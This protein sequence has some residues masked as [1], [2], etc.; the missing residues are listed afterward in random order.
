MLLVGFVALLGIG[1][2]TEPA[3]PID[4]VV[5][6]DWEI[7]ERPDDPWV[8]HR[9]ASKRACRSGFLVEDGLLEIETDD[10][11]Y[12][13]ARQP[14]R[15]DIAPGDALD[16]LTWHSALASTTV[17]STAHYVITIGD[18]PLFEITPDIPASAA[19]YDLQ[20]PVE[21]AMPAGTDVVLHLH[22]HG[23][24]SWRFAHLKVE[25]GVLS[26]P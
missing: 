14:T 20:L 25:P 2:P 7:L 1:C 3:E 10:C 15:V 21:E 22:N 23:A 19:V 6:E 13:S 18:W 4:L 26:G 12:V 16:L 17:G 24:N 9:D 5:P 8:E 11:G